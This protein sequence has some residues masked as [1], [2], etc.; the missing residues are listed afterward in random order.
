MNQAKYRVLPAEKRT[1]IY[2]GYTYIIR[3]P[4]ATELYYHCRETGYLIINWKTDL[5]KP[6]L[7]FSVNGM[8][9]L[10]YDLTIEKNK[11]KGI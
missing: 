8:L 7:Q 10:D 9:T 5:D 6:L 2:Q 3:T 11:L 4:N 1:Q